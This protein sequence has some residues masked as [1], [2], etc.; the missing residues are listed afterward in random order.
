MDYKKSAY[1]TIIEELE[2]KQKLI[3]NTYSGIYGIMDEKTQAVY[4]RIESFNIGTALDKDILNAVDIMLKAGYIVDAEKDELA[5]LKLE[6]ETARYS[7]NVLG[8]T[9]AP[10]LL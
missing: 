1:N 2:D 5:T 9:L 8:F 4:E 6:R 3:Y 7:T 10:F